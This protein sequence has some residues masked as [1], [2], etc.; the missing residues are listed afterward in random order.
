MYTIDLA[1]NL[2]FQDLS[3]KNVEINYEIPTSKAQNTRIY[4]H[5]NS[6]RI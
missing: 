1:Y 6:P 3:T 2:F 4:F 5:F